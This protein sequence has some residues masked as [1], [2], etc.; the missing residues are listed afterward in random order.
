MPWI[1]TADVNR[2]KWLI[3]NVFRSVSPLPHSSVFWIQLVCLIQGL[4]GTPGDP[5]AK[6]VKGK[7]CRVPM[8]VDCDFMVRD[9]E[10]GMPGYTG[11]D[12]MPGLPGL[13]V[14]NIDKIKL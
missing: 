4:D 2:F 5:G 11:L 14:S 9:G 6:G 3:K 13:Q 10:P 8:D 12:G 1:L 7:P